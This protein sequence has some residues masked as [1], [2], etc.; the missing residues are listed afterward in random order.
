MAKHVAETEMQHCVELT[1]TE[2]LDGKKNVAP[3]LNMLDV[4][5]CKHKHLHLLQTRM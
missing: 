3:Y 4:V 5:T 1:D 2:F